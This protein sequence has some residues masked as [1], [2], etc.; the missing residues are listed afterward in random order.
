MEAVRLA[1]FAACVAAAVAACGKSGCDGS[2][3]VAGA[4]SGIARD[5]AFGDGTASFRFT[6]SR[7]TLGGSGELCFSGACR[8]GTFVGR[9][10]TN[11]VSGEIVPPPPA[12][13]VQINASLSSA[14][15]MIGAFRAVRCAQ[16]DRGTFDVLKQ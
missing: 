6:Q 1:L 2:R 10:D 14:A 12:C 4:W 11:A 9:L 7:C 13:P 8:S 3:T 16:S 15:E 5:T